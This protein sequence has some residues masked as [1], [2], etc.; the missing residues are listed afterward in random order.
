MSGLASLGS[1]L[2][3]L[4]LVLLSLDFALDL[5]LFSSLSDLLRCD[6]ALLL[7]K[8][9]WLFPDERDLS[10]VPDVPKDSLESRFKMPFVPKMSKSSSQESPQKSFFGL[11]KESFGLAG[12]VQR[13]LLVLLL[14]HGTSDFT[15]D[16]SFDTSASPEY[17]SGLGRASL[18]EL[19][20][21][22]N[23]DVKM[24]ISNGGLWKRSMLVMPV[25]IVIVE[26]DL[27]AKHKEFVHKENESADGKMAE[28]AISCILIGEVSGAKSVSNEFVLQQLQ[29]CDGKMP[30]SSLSDILN[31][32]FS[33]DINRPNEH[34]SEEFVENELEYGDGKD[35]VGFGF[36][37]IENHSLNDMVRTGTEDIHLDEFLSKNEDQLLNTTNVVE[38]EKYENDVHV[39]Q[40]LVEQKCQDLALYLYEENVV[41]ENEPP[42]AVKVLG[43]LLWKTYKGKTLV[44]PYTVQSPAT[45]SVHLDVEQVFFSINKP[46]TPLTALGVLH[47]QVRVS[48]IVMI[49]GVFFVE[50]TREWW[51]NM[52]KTRIPQYLHDWGILEA[53]CIDPETYN[54]KFD[55]GKD[56]PLQGDAY[57]DCGVWVCINLYRLIHKMS[58]SAKDPQKVGLAYREHMFDY[59]WKYKIAS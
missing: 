9:L 51:S 26:E 41:N 39:D 37:N 15:P 4:D 54:I 23:E 21:S 18:V 42:S 12:L 57:G 52:R 35:N 25:M 34:M 49:H 46:R 5:L 56:V 7:D 38:G 14:R 6:D 28:S 43:Q 33:C 29:S 2:F 45:A 8:L 16:L 24:E 53:K 40:S 47:N 1:D 3:P 17:V 50:E 44:E 11:E 59:F 13:V 36:D 27:V 55:V 22:E 20:E 19:F 10:R 30:E 32:E 48:S 58:L 31:G